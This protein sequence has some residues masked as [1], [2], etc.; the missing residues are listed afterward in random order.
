[1]VS[2]LAL[3][4]SECYFQA[5]EAGE[6]VD[7]IAALRG[8]YQDIRRGIGAEKSPADYGAFPSDPY[9]HTPEN[10]GVKQPGMTGQVKEDILSRFSEIGVHISDGCVDFRLE[11]FD[12]RELLREPRPLTFYSLSGESRTITV[13]KAGFGFT[14]CQVPIICQAGDRDTICIR[15]ASGEEQTIAGRQIDQATSRMLFSRSGEIDSIECRFAA[16]RV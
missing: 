8:H 15:F 4:V 14:L 3:A 2:K 10:S 7:T 6:S 1:M 13:P 16:L 12:R 9:S 11:L 5:V